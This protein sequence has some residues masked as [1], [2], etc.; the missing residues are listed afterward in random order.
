MKYGNHFKGENLNGKAVF[1]FYRSFTNQDVG[2]EY[3]IF[4][5]DMDCDIEHV[6]CR[7]ERGWY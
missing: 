1:L 3:A 2:K 6:F 5:Q 7:Q 4:E